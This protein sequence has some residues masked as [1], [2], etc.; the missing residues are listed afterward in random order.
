MVI[1]NE[2][3]SEDHVW[4]KHR[5]F[6]MLFTIHNAPAGTLGNINLASILGPSYRVENSPSDRLV[7][8][9]DSLDSAA[10]GYDVCLMFRF[11]SYVS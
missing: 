6:A 1:P 3:Q 7:D 9:V 2:G 10:F 8:L 5:T 4:L 11:L